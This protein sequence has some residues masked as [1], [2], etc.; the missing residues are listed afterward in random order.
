VSI[1]VDANL[2]ESDAGRQSLRENCGHAVGGR[3]GLA[4]KPSVS[5]FLGRSFGGNWAA[6]MAHVAAKR[7]RT[8]VAWAGGAL[9]FQEEWLSE[10]TNAESYLYGLRHR[11]LPALR[12]RQCG[13]ARYRLVRAFFATQK[14][15]LFPGGHIGQTPETFPTI[16]DWLKASQ[17]RQIIVGKFLSNVD[18]YRAMA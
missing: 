2:A 1:S 7:L 18:F 4:S 3:R 12:R 5:R 8:E 14:R 13:S 16:L 11:L 15:A 6:K 9:F 17:A 10:S